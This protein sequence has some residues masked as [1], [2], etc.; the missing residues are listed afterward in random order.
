MNSYAVVIGTVNRAPGPNYLAGLVASLRA[1]GLWTCGLLTAQRVCIVDGGSA[2]VEHWDAVRAQ[3]EVVMPGAE[4]PGVIDGVIDFCRAPERLTPNVAYLQVVE[5]GLDTGAPWVITLE[6]DVRVAK[7]F[8]WQ[9]DAWI[10]RHDT[11]WMQLVPLYCPY[12]DMRAAHDLGLDVW[13]YPVQ[14]YYGSQGMLWRRDALAAYADWYRAG[15]IDGHGEGGFCD[16]QMKAWH[17]EAWPAVRYFATPVP[18]LVQHVGRYSALGL[19]ER[20]HS[21]PCCAPLA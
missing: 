7:D 16:M 14:A 3:D 2:T 4:I 6:D 9:L 5:E 21:A 10:G 1:A 19:H 15:G 11:A 18:S 17:L 13:T 12:Q 8:L 20:F